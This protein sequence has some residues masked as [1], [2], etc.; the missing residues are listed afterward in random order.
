MLGVL[1]LKLLLSS[2]GVIVDDPARRYR[3]KQV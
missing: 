2:P 1:S 3:L